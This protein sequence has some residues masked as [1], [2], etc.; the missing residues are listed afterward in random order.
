M[1]V[2]SLPPPQV[3]SPHLPHP[4]PPPTPCGSPAGQPRLCFL[5]ED[6][7]PP[8]LPTPRP[9]WLKLELPRAGCQGLFGGSQPPPAQLGPLWKGPPAWAAADLSLPCRPRAAPGLGAREG[10]AGAGPGYLQEESFGFG[11]P[12]L[13]PIQL[14]LP[15]PAAEKRQRLKRAPSRAPLRAAL[16]ALPLPPLPRAAPQPSLGP[17]APASS[18]NSLLLEGCNEPRVQDVLLGFPSAVPAESHMHK[19]KMKI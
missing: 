9:L 4:P 1:E 3:D 16:P 14:T 5:S 2:T 8:S 15:L 7:P 10:A 6:Y 17:A 11:S 19:I 13:G 12:L 18:P